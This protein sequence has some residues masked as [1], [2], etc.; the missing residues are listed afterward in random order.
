MAPPPQPTKMPEFDFV[1]LHGGA[2]KSSEMKGKVIIIR[3]W[4]TW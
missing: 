4:A 2:L 1:N 3:F